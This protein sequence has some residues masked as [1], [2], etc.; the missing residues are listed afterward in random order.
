MARRRAKPI[1][2]TPAR[3]ARVVEAVKRGLT[4]AQQAAYAGIGRTTLMTYLRLGRSE[5]TGLWAEWVAEIDQAEAQAVAD[6]VDKIIEAAD[7][8]TWQAAA[9]WL[10]RRYPAQWARRVLTE[11]P[12]PDEPEESVE[13][14]LAKWT[15]AQGNQK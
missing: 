2:L 12:P 1:R 10:E 3:R 4:R 15:E 7:K 8:G 11:A 6:R 14:I 5:E 9:W 13:D